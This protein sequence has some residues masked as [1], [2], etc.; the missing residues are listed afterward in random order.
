MFVS[1][2]AHEKQSMTDHFV[3]VLLYSYLC[4]DQFEPTTYG[5]RRFWESEDILASPHF[6]LPP[7]MDCLGV[8]TWF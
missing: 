6:V 7:L 2:A 5:V 1:T 8:K 3:C 4:E